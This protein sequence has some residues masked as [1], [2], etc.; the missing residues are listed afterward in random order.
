MKTFKS[1]KQI[2]K[3]NK[4]AFWAMGFLLITMIYTFLEKGLK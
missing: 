4:I 1:L 2:Y 3:E